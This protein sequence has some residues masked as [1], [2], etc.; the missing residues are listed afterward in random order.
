MRDA[1]S[2]LNDVRRNVGRI[3]LR[4]I[5][6]Y[7][8]CWDRAEGGYE[9]FPGSRNLDLLMAHMPLSSL[10]SYGDDS[11][12]G[13]DTNLR[14]GRTIAVR[15][16]HLIDGLRT[17]DGMDVIGGCRCVCFSHF[18][19]NLYN[20]TKAQTFA[21][22]DG[23]RIM[24]FMADNHVHRSDVAFW[25]YTLPS[26]EGFYVLTCIPVEDDEMWDGHARRR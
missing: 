6:P 16:A 14:W 25:P 26:A 23:D 8:I 9:D 10:G 12:V 15:H 24:A 20:M 2:Q 11:Y 22:H 3:E 18:E 13:L 5:E 17:E 19:S 7:Y 4:E 21:Q 1:L